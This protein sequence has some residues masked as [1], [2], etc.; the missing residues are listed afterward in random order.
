MPLAQHTL[1]RKSHCNMSR[2]HRTQTPSTESGIA[3]IPPRRLR[4][5]VGCR[6]IPLALADGSHPASRS[7]NPSK[8]AWTI[9]AT[10][11]SRPHSR[12]TTSAPTGDSTRST[13]STAIRNDVWVWKSGRSTCSSSWTGKGGSL[14]SCSGGT[15]RP[16]KGIKVPVS[17]GPASVEWTTGSVAQGVWGPG[18]TKV[19]YSCRAG[20]YERPCRTVTLRFNANAI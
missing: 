3:A 9:R 6:R 4:V 16:P 18:D 14:C 12:N 20:L 2:T 11:C 1:T 15:S 10:R 7:S 8:S 5:C 19:R 17:V 13:S